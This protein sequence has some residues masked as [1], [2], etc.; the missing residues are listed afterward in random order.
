MPDDLLEAQ[1]THLV[2]AIKDQFPKMAYLHLVEPRISGSGDVPNSVKSCEGKSLDFLRQAWG[3]DREGSPIFA[4]GGY[5][6][7]TAQQMVVNHGGAVVFGRLFIANPDLPVSLS[8][9]SRSEVKCLN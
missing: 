1:F 5:T 7:D 2:T 9:G 6:L 8:N 4:A 3:G